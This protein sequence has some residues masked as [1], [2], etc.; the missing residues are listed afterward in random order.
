MMLLDLTAMA[1]C[2][3]TIGILICYTEHRMGAAFKLRFEDFKKFYA[4]APERYICET[5]FTMIDDQRCVRFSFL[6]YL[7]YLFWLK[8]QNRIAKKR[9]EDSHKEKYIQSVLGDI[10]KIRLEEAKNIDEAAKMLD[11][12]NI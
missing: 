7:K 1:V 6:D 10:E 12:I 9:T 11:Q 8:A 5:T 4:L 3:G 2:F